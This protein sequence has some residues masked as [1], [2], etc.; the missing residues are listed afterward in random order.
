MA[1]YMP[2]GETIQHTFD[3][4]CPTAMKSPTEKPKLIIARGIRAFDGKSPWKALCVYHKFAQEVVDQV[5]T[6]F[7]FSVS[8]YSDAFSTRLNLALAL[9]LLLMHVHCLDD[10]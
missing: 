2:S 6:L 5:L 4:N 8:Y 7:K 3:A 9:Y 1:S 10:L